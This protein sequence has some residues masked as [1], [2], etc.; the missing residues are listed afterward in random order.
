MN[1]IYCIK[2][3]V[4]IIISALYY[5]PAFAKTDIDGMFD[6]STSIYSTINEDRSDTDT[7][8]RPYGSLL[9]NIAF[10]DKFSFHTNDRIVYR[11]LETEK[12]ANEDPE[13]L[14]LNAYYGYINYRVNNKV[15]IQLGR[16]MDVANLVYSYYDG[17]NLRFKTDLGNGSFWTNVYGGLLVNDDYLDD[18]ETLYGYNSFDVRNFSIEQR[19]GDYICGAQVNYFL[20]R[21]FIVSLDYQMTMNDNSLAEQYVSLDFDTFFSQRIKLYGFGTLDTIEKKP[22]ASL[23]GI[24]VNPLKLI[25]LSVEH[26]YYRPVFIKDSYWW[27]Y[28]ES[29]AHQSYNGILY[30]FFSPIVTLT[31]KYSRLIYEGDSETGNDISAT[32]EDRKILGFSISLTGEFLKGPEGEKRTGMGAIERRFFNFIDIRAGGGMVQYTEDPE[33][34]DLSSGY[35]VRGDLGINFDNRLIIS[36]DAEYFNNPKYLYDTRFFISVKYLF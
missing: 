6:L 31:T 36:A 34:G 20:K 19:T 10:N 24:R 7:N 4:L 13:N 26:E 3:S 14:D 18:E 21:R 35:L 28:F 11:G 9:L 16:I 25:S 5:Y 17:L 15:N 33:S 27:L 2:I 29:L 8:Y 32:L 22:S 1:R 12:D 30:F 23:A